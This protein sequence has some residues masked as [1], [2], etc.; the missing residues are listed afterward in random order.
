MTKQDNI[1]IVIGIIIGVLLSFIAVIVK[2]EIRY[3]AECDGKV[4]S[5]WN[6]KNYCVDPSI[7]DK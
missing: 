7:L 1:N 4:V 2:D 5:D 6:G 3:Y